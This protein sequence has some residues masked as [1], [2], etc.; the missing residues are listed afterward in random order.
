MSAK[1]KVQPIKSML[2]DIEGTVAPITFVKETLFPYFLKQIPTTLRTVEYPIASDT[3]D[4][5]GKI[6]AG[7]PEDARKSYDALLSHINNLVSKDVKDPTLK[8]FQG[9]I[10]ESGYKKQFLKAPLYTDA[11]EFLHTWYNKKKLY[12]YSSGSIKAQK[13]LF[14]HVNYDGKSVDLNNLFAGYFDITTAGY[15][16]ESKSYTSI[17]NDVNIPANEVLFLS[18]NV[19]EVHAAIAAGMQAVVVVRPGNA[20]LSS[21]DQAALQTITSLHQ[22]DIS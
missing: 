17:A 9:F 10:W 19:K 7:F 4:P 22:L 1:V 14:G 11:I 12:I 3:T 21:Q 5:V 18:D 15:K 13:L 20:P 16:T 8:A 2:F 6:L